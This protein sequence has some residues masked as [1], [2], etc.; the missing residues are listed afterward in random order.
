M[1]DNGNRFDVVV[2]GCG[3]AGLSAAVSACQQGAKVAVLERA[4]FEERGGN[5]RYTEGFLRMNNDSEVSDDFE[6]ELATTGSA[7]L[8]PAL[9]HETAAP[10]EQWPAIVRS[11]NFVD[12]EVITAFSS[13]AGPTLQWLK[14]F[15][16]RFDNLP[17][18]HITHS[19]PKLVTVGGGLQLVEILT[20]EAEKSGVTFFYE[21]TAKELIQDQEGAVVGLKATGRRNKVTEFDARAVIL[22][23]GGFEG[24]PE[25]LA[26]YLGPKAVNLR[27]TARGGYYNRGEGIQMALDIGAAPCGN[28]S[29]FHAEPVDPRSGVT[30][31]LIMI[32]PYG[33]LVNKDGERFVDEASRALDRLYE[34]VSY[35][36][37]EQRDGIAYLILDEKIEDVENYQVGVRTDQPPIVADTIAELAEKLEISSL[38]LGATVASFNAA[39]PEGPFS[40]M[41]LDGM[42]TD[43]LKPPKSNWARPI[44][45]APFQA[46]PIIAVNTFTFGGLK[47][48]ASAQVL[49]T[50]GDI[51]PGLYAGGEVIGL[52]FRS[53]AG[54]TS[55]LRGATFGRL[56]GAHAAQ[57]QAP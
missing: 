19:F 16:A 26:H 20:A 3:I 43:G 4:T 29:N 56:G 12:P 37:L 5:T 40:L 38:A 8:D 41:G 39:C 32:F 46:Y 50:D 30:E 14:G 51:I 27:P 6:T 34:P 45:T 54:A 21:T 2:V 13:E 15:G 42:A 11:M 10:Y 52:F 9:V 1:S 18:P 53:Y 25:M 23:S 7:Y 24:N 35:R 22:A 47:V 17:T 31:P 33:I 55:V 48:N 49:N 36:I 28:F 44:D 57:Y